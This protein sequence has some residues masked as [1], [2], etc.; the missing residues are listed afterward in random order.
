MP[1]LK[2]RYKLTIWLSVFVPPPHRTAFD[3]PPPLYN[4]PTVAIQDGIP[5]PP[6]IVKLEGHRWAS[7]SV[8]FLY[9]PGRFPLTVGAPRPVDVCCRRIVWG[10]TCAHTLS[11]PR[12]ATGR[13]Q[14]GWLAAGQCMGRGRSGTGAPLPSLVGALGSPNPHLRPKSHVKHAVR[15]VEYQI[16]DARQARHAPFVGD[17]HICGTGT[18]QDGPHAT[19]AVVACFAVCGIWSCCGTALTSMQMVMSVLSNKPLGLSQTCH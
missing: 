3:P 17:Q 6:S 19:V 18:V 9:A 2:R 8:C 14:N 7:V 11:R 5:L 10:C 16:R 12:C 1:R 15:L 13:P 4:P